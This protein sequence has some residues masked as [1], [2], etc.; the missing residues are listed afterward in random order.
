MANALVREG[1]PAAA[2]PPEGQELAL[3]LMLEEARQIALQARLLSMNAACESAAACA[4]PAAAAEMVALGASAAR[5]AEEMQRTTAAVE[6][7][8]EQI[9]TAGALPRPL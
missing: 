3:R 1:L 5:T 4:E 8:L 6:L 9:R 2:L 7:L